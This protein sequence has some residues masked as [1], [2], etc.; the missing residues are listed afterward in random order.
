M[1]DSDGGPSALWICGARR[2]SALHVTVG[3]E[4]DVTTAELLRNAA[5]PA[6]DARI[7]SLDLREVTFIDSSGLRALVELSELWRGHISIRPGD[8][9]A[10]LLSLYEL[11]ERTPPRLARTPARIAPTR[12][13][14][15]VAFRLR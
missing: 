8:A 6:A 14:D 1:S 15:S 13:A 10:R 12:L 9:V 5:A 3:G 4:L 2:G 7:L 11:G